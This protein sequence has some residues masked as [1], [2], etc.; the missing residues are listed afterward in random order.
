MDDA[1]AI[2]ALFAA[3][4]AAFYSA[5]TSA[6]TT[7]FTWPAT[8][9]QFGEGHVFEDATELA[10]NIEA[11]IDVLDEAGI[12]TT[13]AEVCEVRVAGPSAFAVVTWRQQDPDGEVLHEFGCQYFLL[14]QNGAWR[15]ATVVNEEGEGD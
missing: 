1:E 14:K 3:Y 10:A 5:D 7:L 9:W 11:L 8:I 2:R 6:V 13:T 4:A 12:G 15:I